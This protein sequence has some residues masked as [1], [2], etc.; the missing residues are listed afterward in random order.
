MCQ[1]F[2]VVGQRLILI[3]RATNAGQTTVQLYNPGTAALQL[4]LT[5][6]ELKNK[7][8]SATLPAKIQLSGKDILTMN[9]PP[10]QSVP[11]TISISDVTELGEWEGPL[12]DNGSPGPTVTVRSLAFGA[13]INLPSPDH[14]EIHLAPG[15]TVIIPIR[16]DGP[17][18]YHTYWRLAF[19]NQ[20]I[21]IPAVYLPA[22][23]NAELPL[24]SPDNLFH[25][26]YHPANVKPL[27]KGDKSEGHLTVFYAG[28]PDRPASAADF[29]VTVALDRFSQGW[30]EMGSYVLIFGVLLLGGLS[31]LVLSFLL[32]NMRQRLDLKEKLKA[33]FLR[34]QVLSDRLESKVRVM[35]RVERRSLS[36]LLKSR[37]VFMP[38]FGDVAVRCFAGIKNL[39]SRVDLLVA[40]DRVLN[41]LNRHR[42]GAAPSRIKEVEDITAEI[43]ALL[44]IPCLSDTQAESVHKGIEKA[45]ELVEGLHQQD[46]KF[47]ASLAAHVL[48]LQNDICVVQEAE[49][50]RRLKLDSLGCYKTVFSV[51]HDATTIAPQHYAFVDEHAVKLSL[52]VEYVNFYEG[53]GEDIRKIVTESE[54]ELLR[55]VSVAGQLTAARNLLKQMRESIFECD[56]VKAIQEVQAVE[57]QLNPAIPRP[58]QPV[59]F[60]VRF[61]DPVLDGAAA[62]QEITPKW[63]FGHDDLTEEGAY[64]SHYF[65]APRQHR[66]AR[67][68]RSL[69]WFRSKVKRRGRAAKVDPNLAGGG[70]IPVRKADYVVKV[71]FRKADG[72]NIELNGKPCEI[73]KEIRIEPDRTQS[74]WARAI[75]ELVLLLGALLIAVFGLV[76]GAREQLLK[77]DVLPGLFTIFLIGFGADRIKNLITQRQPPAS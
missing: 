56:I 75:T 64:V 57:L 73:P 26:W 5:C 49:T 44:E 3:D 48:G 67:L 29:L 60:T 4:Y 46:E 51:S 62:R 22:A 58:D 53:I 66:F 10:K 1:N 47:G 43:S 37:N 65:S 13:K 59:E 33:L 12:E 18:A 23:G 25:S 41:K 31:S 63:E 7:Q 9:I 38:D 35:V 36:E 14:P 74:R 24:K 6:G 68:L 70:V 15:R 34:T 52:L 55:R 11:V 8:N 16:N 69:R 30:Q 61:L 21:S 32:P 71:T 42:E 76:A 50:F 77:L 40:L 19:D 20:I 54:K 39:N 17:V 27:L 72:K 2:K 28:A 45:D